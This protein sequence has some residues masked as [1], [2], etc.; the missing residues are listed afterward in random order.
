MQKV[1]LG[2]EVMRLIWIPSLALTWLGQHLDAGLPVGSVEAGGREGW[3]RV[4]GV[5]SSPRDPC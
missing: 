2:G 4:L 3:V 5:A 1:L